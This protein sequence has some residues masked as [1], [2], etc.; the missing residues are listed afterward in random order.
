[1]ILN[2]IE[3][4][5]LIK[6]R[7]ITEYFHNGDIFVEGRDGSEF[8][9]QLINKTGSQ[10][11]AVVSVD[12]R[13]I[14]NGED[15]SSASKGYILDAYSTSVI[16][17]WKLDNQSAAAFVFSSPKQS[18]AAKM[19]G[20][21]RNNG[22]IGLIAYGSKPFANF[23]RITT[24]VPTRSTTKGWYGSSARP[25]DMWYDDAVLSSATSMTSGMA[26]NSTVP[27]MAVAQSVNNLGTGFGNETTFHTTETVFTRGDML[28]RMIMFY[29]NLQGLKARG[30]DVSRYSRRM[31]VATTPQAF[32]A[33]VVGCTP[34]PGWRG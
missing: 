23:R 14:I 27:L 34:P 18:Y 15:A 5:V 10:V 4:N 9:L 28:A 11:E 21:T 16:P 33:D 13:S 2:N 7:P 12:G 31:K 3:L 32:P 30:I 19:S 24:S 25:S 1:M 20:S 29:D 22:V 26:Q 8:E 6:G 17:G